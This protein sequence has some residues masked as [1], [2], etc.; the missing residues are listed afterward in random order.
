M[1]FK[2]RP[3]RVD[4]LPL[5][6]AISV[7]VH[8]HDY[9]PFISQADRS[10]FDQRYAVNT[11]NREV[12]VQ[13]AKKR[14]SSGNWRYWVAVN[15]DDSIIGYTQ[16]KVLNPHHA[17][18]RGMFVL[19]EFQGRGIGSQLMAASLDIISSGTVDLFVLKDN[20]RA[21]TLYERYGFKRTNRQE[22]SFFGAPLIEMSLTK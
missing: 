9:G 7:A 3:A 12:F 20:Q 6:F 13:L 11:E 10:R 16:A 19:S 4:D 21:Q 17:V 8:H 15:T 1:T 22:R 5:L 2:V 14:L 18:K